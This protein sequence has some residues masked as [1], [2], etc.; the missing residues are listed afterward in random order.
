MSK[1]RIRNQ[2]TPTQVR[3]TRRKLVTALKKKKMR[4]ICRSKIL[5]RISTGKWGLVTM[6]KKKAV[7]RNKRVKRET[8]LKTEVVADLEKG[9]ATTVTVTKPN[10]KQTPMK[11]NGV[12]RET[13]AGVPGN[14]KI[15]KNPS[16]DERQRIRHG[17]LMYL[18]LSNL[19]HQV[20]RYCVKAS[21]TLLI[22][23]SH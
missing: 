23:F 7:G 13:E 12:K 20:L 22:F 9:T 14:P 21:E 1:Q 19:E 17:W 11:E 18:L 5:I 15:K 2:V 6:K 3:N 8:D 16:T 10:T 4:T